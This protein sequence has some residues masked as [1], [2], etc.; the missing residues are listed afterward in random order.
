MT[1]PLRQYC[2]PSSCPQPQDLAWQRLKLRQTPK[3]TD[4][5][6]TLAPYAGFPSVLCFAD[7]ASSP[8]PQAFLNQPSASLPAL[9]ISVFPV[10]DTCAV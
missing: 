1:L 9:G 6:L 4:H 8:M 7:F 3:A 5:R 2:S 10:Q